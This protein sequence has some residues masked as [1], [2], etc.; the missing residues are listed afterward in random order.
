MRACGE[1]TFNNLRANYVIE[2]CQKRV[3]RQPLAISPATG[4]AIYEISCSAPE[5]QGSLLAPPASSKSDPT[6]WPRLTQL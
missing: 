4:Q 3:F 1:R 5:N 2:K 6:C